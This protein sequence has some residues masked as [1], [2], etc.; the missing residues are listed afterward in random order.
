VYLSSSGG[1]NIVGIELKDPADWKQQGSLSIMIP[2]DNA[3]GRYFLLVTIVAYRSRKI[4]VLF[5]SL[6]AKW[7]QQANIFLSV[8]GS[9]SCGNNTL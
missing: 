3:D 9:E 6:S 4:G 8:N 7:N 2:S 5:K 1:A